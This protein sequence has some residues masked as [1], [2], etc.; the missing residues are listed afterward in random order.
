VAEPAWI[1]LSVVL[2]IH[3]EQLAEHG[4]ATELRDLHLLE[5]TL[6]RPR[7]LYAY[8]S[9]S[10][11]AL[12]ASYA[13]GIAINHP[14]LDG[15]KRTSFVV[16][17]LFLAVNGIDLTID[18]DGVVITWL[19]LASGQISETELVSWIAASCRTP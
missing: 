2:A 10:L 1:D 15:N 14:F 9:V 13:Y 17:E 4:G 7:N 19:K 5:S 3:D 12:A 6:A 11:A 18:D 16:A 8:E